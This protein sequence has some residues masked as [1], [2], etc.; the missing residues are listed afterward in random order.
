MQTK[1]IVWIVIGVLLLILII[2]TVVIISYLYVR[3]KKR[4]MMAASNPSASLG[5]TSTN[6]IVQTD[7]FDGISSL[8]T[9]DNR[10]FLKCV[11]DCRN[12]RGFT[13]DKIIEVGIK[14]AKNVASRYS[15]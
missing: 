3:N 8:D 2:A 12:S 13:N 10:K 15:S 11:N 4:K 1:T 6:E 5:A 14:G 7:R 9:P